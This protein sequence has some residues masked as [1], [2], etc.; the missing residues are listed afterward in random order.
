M[1]NKHR[2][3]LA[4]CALLVTTLS[5]ARTTPS[6]L[7]DNTSTLMHDGIERTY[8]LHVPASYDGNEAA[9]LVLNF[10]GGGGN[11]DTQIQT[12]GFSVLADEKGFIVA[13]PNGSGRQGDKLLTW[14]GGTCCGYAVTNQIDDVGFVR[15]LIAE[16]QSKYNIDPKRIYATGMS[17]GAIMSYRLACEASDIFAAV[18]PVA[19]TQNYPHCN[20]V[21]PVSVIHFHG[22]DDRHIGYDGGAGPDSLVDVPFTSV[23]DSIDFW[24]NADRCDRTPRT[25]SFE[26]IQHDVYSNCAYG[27]AVELYTVVG[28][29]HA[30][31]G[32]NGPARPGGDEPTQ[33]I[34]ATEIIWN[35]FAAHPKP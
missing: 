22:T 35:F 21:Q 13:Y 27:M 12:S 17:N 4:L 2:I 29:K 8:V 7:E 10:H 9:A 28:G 33:S 26:D 25:E 5:C 34:S 20:P 1:T 31:P 16:V 23:R 15:A 32:G 30:W 18:A 6:Q 19:G 11:A 14:N 24:L 3:I